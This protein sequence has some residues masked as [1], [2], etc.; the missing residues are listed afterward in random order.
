VFILS[1][2]PL[3]AFREGHH[4][5]TIAYD[6]RICIHLEVGYLTKLSPIGGRNNRLLLNLS[7][8]IF[9]SMLMVLT[10]APTTSE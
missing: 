5:P 9:C 4:Q 2:Q 7:L 8:Y 6:V 3:S 10:S 1:D